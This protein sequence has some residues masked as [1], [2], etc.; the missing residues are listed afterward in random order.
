MVA[1]SIVVIASHHAP[2]VLRIQQALRGRPVIVHHTAP[3]QED[4]LRVVRNSR[5]ALVVCHAC[6][7]DVAWLELIASVRRSNPL[8][9]LLGV[10]DTMDTGVVARGIVHGLDDYTSLIPEPTAVALLRIIT[11]AL[12]GLEPPADTVYARVK[13]MLPIGPFAS[14]RYRSAFGT[15][16]T[17][18]GAVT[19]CMALG[20]T[21]DEA[22]R[23]L[24]LDKSKVLTVSRHS[25]PSAFPVPVTSRTSSQ[26]I[27]R[28]GFIAAGLLAGSAVSRPGEFQ[29]LF[30]A[31]WKLA[32]RRIPLLNPFL[33]VLLRG[34]APVDRAGSGRAVAGLT[35][36]GTLATGHRVLK[37]RN[38]TG[39]GPGFTLVELLV[40][41][42]ILGLLVGLF[43]PAVQASREAS[44][45]MGC[46]N[47]MRQLGIALHAY[48]DS[49]SEF[50][51]ARQAS[52]AQM[53]ASTAY[54]YARNIHKIGIY[55]PPLAFPMGTERLGSWLLRVQPYMELSD[56]VSLWQKPMV[57][58]DIYDVFL[59]VSAMR[60]PAYNCPS[61]IQAIKGGT[62]F[63]L[64]SPISPTAVPH[65][66]GLTSY[67]GVTGNDEHVDNDGFAS[68]ATNGVFPTMSAG[69]TPR[70]KVTMKKITSGLSKVVMVGER[71]PSW[72]NVFGRWHITDFDSVM[73]NPNM[74]F[75][76]V[77]YGGNGQPCPSP[78][79]C[80]LDSP[81]N[82][83]AATHF[84]SFHP[85]GGQWLLADGSVTFIGYS[86]GATVLPA[87]SSINGTGTYRSDCEGAQQ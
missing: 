2:L 52:P 80:G 4:I 43:L 50:P 86:A 48:H 56:I 45:Q 27:A 20:L 23:H 62:V 85:G 7:G 36:D 63:Y 19:Q 61:D 83:C 8:V 15:S 16:F 60:V 46:G 65:R 1:G 77:P 25:D 49:R 69:L 21:A 9:R 76:M 70:P 3:L 12:A 14:G 39:F 51:L 72:N 81:N 44:R 35:L 40:V 24:T 54:F 34:T 55:D 75:S 73:G 66:Y 37:L 79:F 17:Q 59:Q 6:K 28:I 10:G 87:M 11:A 26:W 84:W 42:A 38:A 58:N 64:R 78:G 29:Y 13:S 71:P 41:I 82:P 67:L 22:A 18:A 47:N 5:K 32:M 68:N 74:E 31:R 30:S 53:Q 57:L 33:I